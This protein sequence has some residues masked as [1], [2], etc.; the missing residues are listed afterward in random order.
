MDNIDA[1]ILSMLRENARTN[2]VSMAKRVGLTEGAI[3]NR[4]KNL[5]K[6]GVIR[7]FTIEISGG[8]EA[9]VLIKTKADATPRVRRKVEELATKLFELSGAYD[10]AALLE[11]GS[12]EELNQKVDK[13]RAIQGVVE[14][15]TMVKLKGD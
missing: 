11:G 2:Y 15:N 14:T 7:K 10:I 8:A 12:T 6:K 4:V 3:R 1:E 5:L 13:I 9:L